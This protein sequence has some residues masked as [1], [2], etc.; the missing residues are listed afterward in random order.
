[1][2]F[3]V[4]DNVTSNYLLLSMKQREKENGELL[5]MF[6]LFFFTHIHCSNNVHIYILY[7]KMPI[8]DALWSEP[9]QLWNVHTK[10]WSEKW[11]KPNSKISANIFDWTD[12]T[13]YRID[14]NIW[15]AINYVKKVHSIFEYELWGI[16]K[17]KF[18]SGDNVIFW[19]TT[20]DFVERERNENA[21]TNKNGAAESG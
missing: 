16:K 20:I 18:I 19:Q 1:M 14:S 2:F 6:R 11:S 21:C 4:V 5:H 10:I 15:G 7:R 9:W 3:Y 12:F 13:S 8:N 17:L